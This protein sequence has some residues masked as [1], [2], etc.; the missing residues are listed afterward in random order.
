MAKLT[1]KKCPNCG[2]P[3]VLNPGVHDVPCQY[4]G[5]VIHVEWGRKAP[6]PTQAPPLTVYVRPSSGCLPVWILLGTVIPIMLPLWFA[7]GPKLVN[8]ANEAAS[9]AGIAP[10]TSFPVTCGMNQEV[11]IIGQTFEGPGTLING[12]INCK[13]RIKDSKLKGDLVVSAKN[14]VEINVE[15]ST[16][17]GKEAAVR[18][19]MN[20]KLFARKNSVLKGEEAGVLAG[21]NSEIGL[22]DSSVESPNSGIRADVNCRLDGN[23][24]KITGG[25]YGLRANSNLNV[26]GRELSISGGRV[27][28]E[29]EVN[30]KL[31]LRGGVFDGK[32]AAVHM[33]GPN[34]ALKLGQKARLTAR[35][36]A[37][38][39]E[40]NLE[41]EMEDALIDGGEIGIETGVNPKLTLN[42][43][44]RVVGKNVALKVGHNLELEMRGASLESDA[45]AL[46]APFNA[47]ISA[48]E[49]VI[50]GGRQALRMQRKPQELVLEQSTVSGA[51][52]FNASGCTP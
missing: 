38:D 31:E 16:L 8:L 28:L 20:S 12:D 34:A 22:Q 27:A 10:K 9:E 35:E 50:R 4:C 21:I 11:S 48:R 42:K 40:S 43:N 26:T 44:A 41:L 13:I 15:N 5:N 37:L 17:E 25:E 29:S 18:L 52:V 51:Q 2:A 30:L 49:S 1:S 23:N 6:P 45:I 14:L 3:L 47:E 36:K 24:S 39:T 46:C 32:E 19:G 7:F 33:K